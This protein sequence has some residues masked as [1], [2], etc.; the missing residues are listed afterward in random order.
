[1]SEINKIIKHFILLFMSSVYYCT[2]ELQYYEMTLHDIILVL[3]PAHLSH[4]FTGW[5]KGFN[6]K[7]K[8]Q[9]VG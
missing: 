1:M 7:Q 2:N 9:K 8:T 3:N 6:V 4:I 5:Y